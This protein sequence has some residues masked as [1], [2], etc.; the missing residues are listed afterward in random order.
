MFKLGLGFVIAAPKSIL[1]AITTPMILEKFDK[2]DQEGLKESKTLMF[3]GKNPLS[4]GISAILNK[5]G[6]QNFVNKFKDTNFPLH[7]ISLTDLFTT[8]V[9]A[10]QTK[11][12]KKLHEKD[13]KPLIYNSF[14]ATGLSIIS[15][16]IIDF[17]TKNSTDKFIEKYKK[18]NK[19]DINLAK[20]IEGI[21]IA[22]P[23]IILGLVYYIF[24]PMISTFWADRIKSGKV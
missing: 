21:K 11:K 1:T 5:E 14:I 9:F 13:K 17:L 12:S 6:Y 10:T 7:I 20:Q 18:A 16:Y 8:F 22:K 23:M 15:S 2:E 24:I 19:N 4:S 3:K